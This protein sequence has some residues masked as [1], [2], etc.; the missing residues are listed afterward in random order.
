M[1][2]V[3]GQSCITWCTSVAATVVASL[4]VSDLVATQIA[5]FVLKIH[6]ALT[7]LALASH[8][9]ALR[10]PWVGCVTVGTTLLVLVIE[11][12]LFLALHTLPVLRLL[13]SQRWWRPQIDVSLVKMI[14]RFASVAIWN[15]I[16]TS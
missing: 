11:H 3:S 16:C 13:R 10:A 6:I 1:A 14:L 15:N 4:T 12:I 8:F 2:Q 5:N 7:L 9:V